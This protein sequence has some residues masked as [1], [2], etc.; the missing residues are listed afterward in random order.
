MSVVISIVSVLIRDATTDT[1][2]SESQSIRTVLK[3]VL[4]SNS[5][6][7]PFVWYTCCG[8]Y[9]MPYYHCRIVNGRFSEMMVGADF[10]HVSFP[11]VLSQNIVFDLVT[12]QSFCSQRLQLTCAQK[13]LNKVS[14]NRLL[15]LNMPPQPRS[16]DISV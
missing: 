5:G 2:V 9:R 10:K 8:R 7:V 1:C 3:V 16:D 14:R 12:L 15:V 6:D 4:L 13:S 11:G